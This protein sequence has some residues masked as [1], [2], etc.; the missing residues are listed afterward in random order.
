MNY[1]WLKSYPTGI[2][3]EV[4]VK[5]YNNL[6]EVFEE[7]CKKFR[8]KP[9]LTN[10]G[11]TLTYHDYDRLTGQFASYL[12]HELKLKK[13]DRIA[14]Q[15]PNLLQYNIA[16]F[17]AFRAGLVVVNTNPLYTARENGASIQRFRRQSHSHS[18][19]FRPFARR[20]SPSDSYS[21]CHRHGG[22]RLIAFSKRP[23]C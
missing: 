2:P 6:C 7:A 15:M 21:T 3:Y 23:Y 8:E 13:G 9:A 16:L 17:G 19:Q 22:W 5:R 1:P 20:S 14:I 11:A 10:L 18:C 12:Q 4:D